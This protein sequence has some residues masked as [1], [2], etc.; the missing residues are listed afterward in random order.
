MLFQ[1]QDTIFA[2]LKFYMELSA[3]TAIGPVDGRYRNQLQQ[4]DAYFSEFALIKYRILVEVEYFIFLGEKKFF[5]LPAAVKKHLQ[6]SAADFS[7][8]DAQKIKDIEKIT[9]HDVKA[10]EYFL[11]QQL[12]DCNAAELKE[13]IHFGLTSQDIN[14]TSIPLSWKH[15]VEHEY[16]PSLLN[17]QLSLIHI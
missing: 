15:A 7:L 2:A 6:K 8:A 10:V 11:K 4:L 5:K 13:W 16:L 12:D 3:L 9:N 1:K 14:N 17:L